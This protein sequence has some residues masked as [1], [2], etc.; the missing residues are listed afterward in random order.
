[1]A[2]AKSLEDLGRIEIKARNVYGRYL[3]ALNRATASEVAIHRRLA[4]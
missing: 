4:G 2:Q 1:M 3:E